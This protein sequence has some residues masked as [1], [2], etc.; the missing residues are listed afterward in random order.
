MKSNLL[1]FVGAMLVATVASAQTE[2]SPPPPP[3]PVVQPPPPPPPEPAVNPPPAG[4][5]QPPSAA[6]PGTPPPPSATPPNGYNPYGPQSGYPYSPYG[7]AFNPNEKPPLEVGLMISESLFGMLTAAGITLIP[8]FLLFNGNDSA[9]ALGDSTVTSVVFLVIFAAVPL[10]TAQTETSLANGS[11]Y[12]YTETWPAALI[13]LAGEA[14]VLGLYYL[15]GWLPSGG[16]VSGGVPQSG[17]SVLLL[18]IGSIAIVPLLQMAAVNL[19]KSPRVA[20]WGGLI[21]YDKNEGIALGVPG[22]S[23]IV[24]ET[25]LGRAYGAQI[26]LVNMVF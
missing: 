9:H 19:F 21:T 1:I 14:A 22:A 2:F 17:G 18:M 11:R 23:P 8:Y 26:N 25:K 24:G 3:P 12:Y 15:T 6:A 4:T 5:V 16:T 7:K 20:R 10:A 13:G